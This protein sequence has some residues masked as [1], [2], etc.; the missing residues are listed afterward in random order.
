MDVIRDFETRHSSP[1]A[2]ALL[3]WAAWTVESLHYLDDLD[4]AYDATHAPIGGHRPDVV[5]VA[6][7]RWAAGS[8]ITALDLCAAGLGRTF[9]QQQGRR[10]LN[11]GDFDQTISSGQANRAQRTALLPPLARNWVEIV[12][13]DPQY[14]TIKKA[15]D[16]LTHSR[17]RRHFTLHAGGP[18]TRLE[19]EV[20][21]KIEVRQLIEAARDCATKHVTRLLELLPRL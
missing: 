15:R 11:L 6:H 9:C 13:N 10:E 4:R 14:N 3:A 17:I 8:A 18:P 7:A 19:L 21:T 20:E 5:D 12:C 16:W 1:E 2:G